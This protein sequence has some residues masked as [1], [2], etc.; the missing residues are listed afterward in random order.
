MA[1]VRDM[2]PHLG[3]YEVN[4]GSSRRHAGSGQVHICSG[5]AHISSGKAQFGSARAQ[6]D[7]CTSCTVRQI[8]RH[9][10]SSDTQWPRK[11]IYCS[12]GQT[13]IGSGEADSDLD[14]GKA[15]LG[16]GKE[17]LGSGKAYFGS[18]MA[19]MHWLK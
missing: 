8:R 11:I 16:S 14:A 3:S 7:S 5:K 10:C 17:H 13:H 1:Q 18:G 2:V 4:L 9:I 12:M 19:N 15:H 6:T